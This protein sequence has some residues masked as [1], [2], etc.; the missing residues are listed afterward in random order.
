[1]RLSTRGRFAITALID[2][3]LSDANIPVPLSEIAVRH[4][5]SLSYLEQ[6]FAKLRR[7]GLVTST[8]GPGG[9]YMLG[10]SGAYI[11]VAD[12]LLAIDDDDHVSKG[13][14][15]V[16]EVTA[17]LWK[18]IHNTLI[19]HMRTISLSSLAEEQHAKGYRIETR[20]V[21]GESP[22]ISKSPTEVTTNA[23]NSVFAWSGT[24]PGRK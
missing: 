22:L 6:V 15:S 20:N 5:I 4:R 18:S 2:L 17:D 16:Q 13:G 21:G 8:R 7:A 23:E 1:M 24:F 11:S 10:L 9:G 14:D 12:I 3:A 19:A